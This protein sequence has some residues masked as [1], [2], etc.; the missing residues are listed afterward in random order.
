MIHLISLIAT[1]GG[2]EAENIAVEVAHRMGVNG[3]KLGSQILLFLVVAFVL[4]KYAFGPI[5][6]ILAERQKR[7]EEGLDN[8]EKIKRELAETDRL[9]KE[10]LTKANEQA[11]KMIEE[12]KKSASAMSEKRILEAVAQ[13]EALIKKA[14]EATEIERGR[15]M[16][17]L[18]AEVGRL[19]VETTAKVVGKVL[20]SDDQKR[21]REEAIK[22]MAA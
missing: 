18:K 11:E 4:N 1:A 20:T 17:E 22:Q 15:M 2:P 5:Q 19:V 16:M 7:I 8:A 6:A 12:A 21:L 3:P 13:A 10:I 9:K 14:Q